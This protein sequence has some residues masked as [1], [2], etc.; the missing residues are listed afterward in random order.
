VIQTAGDDTLFNEVGTRVEVLDARVADQ[1]LAAVVVPTDVLENFTH[2]G[3][4]PQISEVLT[5]RRKET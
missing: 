2:N 3:T 4:F 5:D 1:E